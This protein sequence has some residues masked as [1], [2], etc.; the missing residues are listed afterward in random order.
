MPWVTTYSMWNLFRNCRKACYWR[1]LKHLVP[2]DRDPNLAFGSLIHQALE[3]WHRDRSLPAVLVHIDRSYPKRTQDMRQK[4]AWH[5][6]TAMMKA[7][8]ARYPVE[9]FEVVALEKEFRGKIINPATGRTSRRLAMAGKVDGIVLIN[10]EYFLFEH[11]TAAQVDGAY[12]ERLW[13][14]FQIQLYSLYVEKSLGIKVTGVLYNI[15]V[16]ARLKQREGETEAEYLER[17]GKLAAQSKS[18]RSSAKRREPESDE[19]YQERLATKYAEPGMFHREMLYVSQDQLRDIQA[20]LWELTQAFLDARRR[21]VF[22]TNTGH[23]F[24][25]GRPCPYFPLCRAGGSP[26]V[27]ENLYYRK[28]PHEELGSTAVTDHRPSL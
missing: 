21:G 14:D 20:E 6:A 17:K 1:Y 5:L 11:K 25:F 8:E 3:Q 15:L 10:G 13:C 4:Q 12:L 19:S 24:R 26:T 27:A 16:K 18:G 22:Y 2:I 28:P 7:Y 9:D 23:C